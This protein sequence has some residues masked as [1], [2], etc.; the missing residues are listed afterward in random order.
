MAAISSVNIVETDNGFNY[1]EERTGLSFVVKIVYGN[2]LRV[3]NSTMDTIYQGIIGNVAK[4]VNYLTR[5]I[6]DVVVFTFDASCEYITFV[7][8]IDI[9]NGAVGQC[10]CI[11]HLERANI[12]YGDDFRYVKITH[13]RK[14]K[15]YRNGKIRFRDVVYSLY[16]GGVQAKM[17]GLV[18]QRRHEQE[19]IDLKNKLKN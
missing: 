5:Q 1:D 6:V 12:P 8:N 4:P 18:A 9:G 15:A 17:L 13:P 3:H 14:G 10:E 16:S 2:V 7:F 19:M 11:L